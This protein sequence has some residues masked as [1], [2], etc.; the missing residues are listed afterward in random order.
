[1]W[2]EARVMVQPVGGKGNNI[3][4][5]KLSSWT[6]NHFHSVILK[7]F[8]FWDQRG[9]MLFSTMAERDTQALVNEQ[10]KFKAQAYP[11]P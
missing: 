7:V 2:E 8:E 6:D 5:T 3:F 9:F 4:Q 10:L 11:Q 1:M